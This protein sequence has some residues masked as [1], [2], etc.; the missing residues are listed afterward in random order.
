MGFEIPGAIGAKMADPDREIYAFVGDGTY[1]MMP[2]EIATAVQ[3]N[4]KIIIILVDNHGF[5][6]IGGLSES[7]GSAG[8]GT[9]YYAPVDYASNA[10]SLGAYAIRANGLAEFKAALAEAKAADRI[11]VI[12][13]ETERDASVPGYDSWWD[14]AV[15]EVSEIRQVREARVSYEEARRKERYYL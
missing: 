7:L 9:R 5:G 12:V 11:S 4:V 3:E 10:R 15:A 13:V 2:S 14:V 1:L 8:F 6:S